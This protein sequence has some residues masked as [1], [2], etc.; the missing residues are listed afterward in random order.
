MKKYE[1]IYTE[2]LNFKIKL[3][4]SKNYIIDSINHN[5]KYPETVSYYEGQLDCLMTTLVNI[6]Y[7][8]RGIESGNLFERGE[9]N[10]Y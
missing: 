2:L 1:N 8:I 9:K 6:N 7:I 10:E 3:L 4:D 5:D